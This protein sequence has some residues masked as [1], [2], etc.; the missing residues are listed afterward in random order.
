[1]RSLSEVIGPFM[2]GPSS[3][4]TAGACR[5][6]KISRLIVNEKIKSV[7]FYLHGS[8]GKNYKGYGTDRALVAGILGMDTDDVRI[9]NSLEIAE[10][11]G[12]NISF[13]EKELGNIYHP[14]TV[15]LEIE[16]LTNR[17][18]SIIASSIGGGNIE[19]VDINGKDVYFTGKYNTLFIDYIDKPGIVYKVSKILSINDINIAYLRVLE[20]KKEI[21][22]LWC[23]N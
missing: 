10:R 16:T 3:S 23:L 12:L 4:H 6:G 22:L 13:I 8:F 5:I 1:M 19:I 20:T 9:I 7:V 15:K 21:K 17:K 2:I 11:S 14:N 18:V